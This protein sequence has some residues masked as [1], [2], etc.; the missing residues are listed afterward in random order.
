MS[1]ICFL[2]S[3]K[4]INC[5]I[6]CK[7]ILWI[8]LSLDILHEINSHWCHCLLDKSLSNLTNSM[9]RNTSPISHNLFS[10]FVFDIFINRN[11]ILIFNTI[12]VETKV[13]INCST[14]FIKLSNSEWCKYVLFFYSFFFAR[15][16]NFFFNINTE[17]ANFTPRYRSFKALSSKSVLSSKIS[18]VSNHIS[19]E[20]TS[21]SIGLSS[22]HSLIFRSNLLNV[23][24]L[25]IYFFFCSFKD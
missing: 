20:I 18:N 3:F 16:D 7:H 22:F 6:N 17:S 14:C 8:N 9:M 21:D 1:N 12:I 4:S 24:F 10:H 15:L 23:F 5:V 25:I 11:Y 19:K 2:F 13:N